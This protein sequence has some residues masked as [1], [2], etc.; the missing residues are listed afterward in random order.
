MKRLIVLFVI[1]I[2]ANSLTSLLA[3]TNGHILK[4][5]VTGNGKKV[6]SATIYILR[7]QDSSIFKTGITDKD[8]AFAIENV[9]DGSY[10]LAV[11]AIGYKKFYSDVLTLTASNTA[12]DLHTITLAAADAAMHTV[13]VTSKRPFIEQKIDKTVVNVEASPTN[14]GL[15]ALEVLEKSPGVT[16]DNNNNI[17]LKGKQGV[18]ILI[19]GKPTYLSGEDLANYLKNLSANQL[20]QIEIMSQPSAKYDA[21]GNSGIINIKTK[22]NK[23]AGFNGNISTSAIIAAYFK[24]TN[25]INLN[26]RKN[27]VNLFG[28]YGYSRWEGFNDLYINRSLRTGKEAAYD[29]YS[30]QYSFNRYSGK[31]QNFKAGIDYYATK[32]T[33]LGAAVTG[34]FENNQFVSKSRANIYDSLYNFVQFNQAHS[35]SRET[36]NNLGFNLNFQQKLDTLGTELTADADYIFYHNK[37]LQDNS[38]YL[39]SSDSVL[40]ET[41]DQHN[42]NPYLLHGNLPSNIDIYTFKSDFH[43]PFKKDA[44]LEAGIKISYVKTDNNAQ[45]TLQNN[46]TKERF[47][48]TTRSNHFIYKENINAAYVNLQKQFKKWG[49]QLGLRAEQTIADGKQV[50]K[51]Q[52]FHKNYTKLFPTTYLSYKANDKNTFALSYGRRIERPGYESLNPFQEQLDRYTYRQ[53]NPLLQPQFSHNIELS[54]NYKGQLNIS[55]NYTNTTDIINDVLITVK[56][57]GDSNYTTFQT[58]QNIASS[59]NIGLSVNYNKQLVKWWSVNVFTNVYYNHYKG[60]INDGSGNEDINTGMAGL[61]GNM[62]NQFNFGKGWS[63]ELS[64]WFRSQ[65]LESST[66]LARSMGMFSFGAGKKILNDKGSIRLNVRDPFYLARFRGKNETDKGLTVISNK[67]DNRRVTISFNYRFGKANGQQQRRRSSAS[68]DEQNRIHTGGQQ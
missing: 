4:G 61:S 47:V 11:E 8:G 60:V 36:W 6:E 65:Q 31:P 68:E 55:T 20:D 56:Q 29:R 67:W 50:T 5:M 46:D 3:Q 45:Y 9:E 12:F 17:S 18:I 15:S 62:S 26:W 16:I 27:K 52:S 54:Y 63:G 21:S 25:S 10:L 57:P 22:K 19:D 41:K 32:K 1:F 2:I 23:A 34:N 59:E 24:N 38:N 64:G 13:V 39:F 53:G 44:V 40:I 30:N 43:H 51:G 42:P 28:N 33:T 49:V 48:D 66:I 7:S 58:S 35:D 14:T 37:N